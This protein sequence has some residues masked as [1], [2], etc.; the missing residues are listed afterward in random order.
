MSYESE[1]TQIF[2]KL[3]AKRM[4][5]VAKPDKTEKTAIKQEDDIVSEEDIM[6]TLA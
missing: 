4:I 1:F 3:F 2:L 5:P 6:K